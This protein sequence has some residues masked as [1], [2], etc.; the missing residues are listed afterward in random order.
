LTMYT[1]L[2]SLIF[3]LFLFVGSALHLLAHEGMW[4]PLFLQKLNEQEM[5]DMGLRISIN[6]IYSVNNGSLKDAV[7]I[8]GGGCTSELISSQGLLLTNHHCGY[9]AIQSHSSMANNYL[10]DGFMAKTQAE[11]LPSQGLTATRIVRIDEVTAAILNQAVDQN[12][13]RNE[14]QILAN[15]QALKEKTAAETGYTPVI[16]SFFY[17]NQYFLFLT[18]VFTDIRMVAAPPSYI[19]KFGYDEDN[20]MWPRHT[21]D[22]SIFRIYAGTDNKPAPYAAENKPYKPYRHLEID[23]SGVKEG[24]FTMVYGFPGQT[25]E[26]L[27]SESIRLLMDRTNPAR[28]ELRQSALSVINAAM[29]QSPETQLQYAAKQSRISN[30][31]KKWIGENRGLQKLN[32]VQQRQ[33]MEKEFLKL[34]GNPETLKALNALEISTA[35]VQIA[36]E[37]YIEF[38]QS[39]PELPK[40]IRSY[41]SALDNIGSSKDKAELDALSL[42]TQQQIASFYEKT[43]LKVD[44]AIFLETFPVLK[45]HLP[46]SYWPESLN[47]QVEGRGLQVF[48][49]GLY[50]SS[51][52]ASAKKLQAHWDKSVAASQA[53]PEPALEFVRGLYQYLLTVVQPAYTTAN[54]ERGALMQGYMA[55]VLKTFEGK[56]RLYP[57]ANGTLRLA[58]G[59]VEGYSPRSGVRYHW[60][61]TLTGLLEKYQKDHPDFHLPDTFMRVAR[62]QDFQPYFYG[63]DLPVAFIGSNHTTGGNSGSPVLNEYGR[64]VGLNFDRTWESTMSDIMFDP[65]RCRNVACDVRYICWVVDKVMGGPHLIEEMTLIEPSSTRMR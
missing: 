33:A 44:K 18:E 32:A 12:G 40:F 19:G 3:S 47:S 41:L 7:F 36:Y 38:L 16:K 42:K 62:L 57:D 52:F 39:G 35:D 61:T 29:R 1:F 34:G 24:D 50:E 13:K 2:R 64:L 54:A 6:E 56:R 15:I 30:Y 14:T 23:L 31:W 8:F 17:G 11:E 21:G 48:L 26:Y 58:Y 43:D 22:F 5:K 10:R 20:W 46:S 25:Q 37:T 9:S 60:Q 65:E 28:I 59:K 51:V 55:Q 27:P 45:K 4:L 53:Q 49:Q 63:K